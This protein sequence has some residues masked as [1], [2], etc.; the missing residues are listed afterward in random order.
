MSQFRKNLVTKVYKALDKNGEGMILMEDFKE[1]YIASRH[2]DVLTK[3]RTED[4]IITEFID[5]FE[6]FYYFTVFRFGLCFNLDRM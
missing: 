1:M 2:P 5:T 4:D 6:E 3:K